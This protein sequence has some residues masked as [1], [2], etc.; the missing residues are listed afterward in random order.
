MTEHHHEAAEANGHERPTWIVR[1]ALGVGGIILL[2]F[3]LIAWQ[4][5]M[6]FGGRFAM[7]LPWIVVVAIL[8]GTAAVIESITSTV[9]IT[10][11]GG[12][13]VV[14]AA[15][16]IAGR[17]TVEF[18]A[19]AHSVFMVDRFTGEARLC[20]QQTC[21]SLGDADSSST[22]EKVSFTLPQLP[23]PAAAKH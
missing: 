17:F 5:H 10:L 8:L 20:N 1:L 4:M 21:R 7:V 2:A 18:D 12:L 13:F 6:D 3:A 11:I 19:P 9:W 23:K 14:I 16:L 22:T 15:F